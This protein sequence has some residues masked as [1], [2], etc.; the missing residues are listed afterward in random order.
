MEQPIA[1]TLNR[2]DYAERTQDTAAL[3][4]R[5]LRSR[6]PIPDG[7]RLTFEASSD[8]ERQLRDVVAAEARCCAFLRMDLQ[9]AEDALV[10]E[11][12]GPA[13]AEPIIA[14]LFA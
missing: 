13:E 3:A 5:A 12:T 4:R 7:T 9:P 11:I 8:T 2:A 6:E 10:L 1:C 14:E